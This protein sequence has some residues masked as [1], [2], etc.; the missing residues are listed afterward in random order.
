MYRVPGDETM[1]PRK[2]RAQFCSNFKPW[3]GTKRTCSNCTWSTD[4][5][6]PC[7]KFAAGKG[8][9]TLRAIYPAS[10]KTW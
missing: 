1:T 7:P 8:Q 2:N 5:Y 4:P 9:R 6:K 3:I 10:E